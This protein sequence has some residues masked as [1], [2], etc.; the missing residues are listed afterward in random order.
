M[1]TPKHSADDFFKKGKGNEI[2]DLSDISQE[3]I[4]L[5]K[6]ILKD[7]H[8]YEG[9]EYNDDPSMIRFVAENHQHMEHNYKS[10]NKEEF[11]PD[12]DKDFKNF[13]D[14]SVYKM[15]KSISR[16]QDAFALG[17][18]GSLTAT[19]LL[20]NEK[21]GMAPEMLA[22][23]DSTTTLGLV[24]IAV[25]GAA[26]SV[27]GFLRGKMQQKKLDEMQ[28]D[29]STLRED[30]ANDVKELSLME[31]HNLALRKSTEM[32]QKAHEDNIL[33]QQLE[34]KE[35]AH[36]EAVNEN[37]K[38][39]MDQ[40]GIGYEFDNFVQRKKYDLGK[41]L[42]RSQELFA[43]SGMTACG[44]ATA[45]LFTTS[46]MG[47]EIISPEHTTMALAGAAAL[48]LGSVLSGIKM[49]KDGLKVK[50]AN[51]LENHI[52]EFNQ[53]VENTDSKLSRKLSHTEQRRMHIKGE[54]A[55]RG[56]EDRIKSY[57]I[58]D[59]KA[60]ELREI[61]KEVLKSESN[62]LDEEGYKPLPNFNKNKLR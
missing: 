18:I 33:A 40:K 57:G 12:F 56:L 31:R 29:P 8:N 34:A 7:E 50:D 14:K 55:E 39:D 9:V 24:G 54:I 36:F 5:A 27:A 59:Q 41:T 60:D 30:F 23:F 37:V 10:D 25:S 38:M 62:K 53:T 16:C 46:G 11:E 19:S 22:N 6:R 52:D 43:G 15:R 26:I 47:P 35:R 13:F 51:N 17:G 48:G 1:L 44:L 45:A 61:Q 20:I 3:D 58:S 4:E 42:S 49:R 32:M 28:A 21:S 2:D